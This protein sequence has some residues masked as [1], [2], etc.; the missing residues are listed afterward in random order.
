LISST[1]IHR[2]GSWVIGGQ[3]LAAFAILASLRVWSEYLRPDE[4]GLMGLIVGA[5][6]MMVGFVSGPVSQAVLVTYAA[7]FRDGLTHE[8]RAVSW[9]MTN[10]VSTI[11]ALVLVVA[12]LPLSFI[13]SVH[14]LTPFL[15][16]A[17]FLVDVRRSFEVVLLIAARRQKQ[18]ALI[19][20]GDAWFRLM[21]LWAFLHLTQTSTYV[22]VAA[23]VFSAVAFLAVMRFLLKRDAY[24]PAAQMTPEVRADLSR[25][26]SRISRP[27]FPAFVLANITQMGSRYLVGGMLGMS[28]AGFFVVADGLARR[29]FGMLSGMI[30][31]T[32]KPLLSSAIANGDPL[33]AT[34]IRRLWLIAGGGIALLGVV[35]FYF[36]GDFVGSLLLTEEYAAS[37]VLLFP[38]ACAMMISNL[39]QAFL[40]FTVCTGRTGPVFVTNAIGCVAT[41]GFVAIGGHTYGLTGVVTG[42]IGGAIVQLSV[43]IVSWH[44]YG[45]TRAGF[46]V[47]D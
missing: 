40:A 27:L 26:L 20:A 34:L 21:F 44:R 5:A 22:A 32:L 43:A 42:M 39:S 3:I 24:P 31:W 7:Y 9:G 35:L 25:A 41:V 10:R 37:Y 23:Y 30:D 33:R 11:A 17:L 47:A 45:Q 46:D 6:S 38:L 2:E 15:I 28:A 13:L 18:V 29:P 19:T 8:H 16:A 36:L 1:Q 14:W 12:G 4:V